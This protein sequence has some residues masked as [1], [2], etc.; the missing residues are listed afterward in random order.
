MIERGWAGSM[1]LTEPD[2]GSDVGAGVT[3]AHQVDGN[4]YHLEGVKRFITGGEHDATENIIHLVLARPDGAGPGTKGLSLFIVPKFLVN[5]DGTLGERNG[6]VATRIEHKLGLQRF[7]HRRVDA[8]RA[9]AGGRLSRRRGPRRNQADVPH[10]RARPDDD[11][12]QVGGDVVDRLPQCPRV[13]DEPAA[14]GRSRRGR[15]QE[16]SAGADHSPPRCP[17]DVAAAE[18]PCRRVAGAVDVRRLVEGSSRPDRGGALG[19]PR[20]FP[21]APRQGLLLGEGFRTSRPIAPDLRRIRAT[22]RT[23]RSSSTSGTPRSTASTRAPP[24]SRPWISSSARS[25]AIRAKP[26]RTSPSKW[27]TSSRAATA[28]TH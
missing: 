23:I 5:P 9:P 10:H 21:V 12:N 26:L 16:G 1:V 19:A 18:G 6:I 3:R 28:K 11:W 20:R 14:G 22:P 2:A 27:P 24:E 25:S 7:H 13:R 17:S 4:T 8:W 15:R